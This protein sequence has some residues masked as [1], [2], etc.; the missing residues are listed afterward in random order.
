MTL[1]KYL[2][3]QVLAYFIDMGI[4][5]FLVSMLFISPFFANIISKF[6]A[7]IFAFI[8]QRRFTFRVP[9]NYRM[10]KQAALYFLV[11]II[12]IPV[13][14]AILILI[15]NFISDAVLAKFLSDIA[16][17]GISYLL[18]KNIIFSK[19]HSISDDVGF[20]KR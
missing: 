5:I 2:T 7:G 15:L 13:A 14:S 11:L 18:S 19:G 17:I 4:Y 8:I 1:I 9:A 10:C 16:C 3:V 12:N 20:L 6:I